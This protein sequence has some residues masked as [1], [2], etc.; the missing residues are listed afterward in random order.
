MVEQTGSPALNSQ[1]RL[2]DKNKQT[3]LLSSATTTKLY[4]CLES[5]F[6]LKSDFFGENPRACFSFNWE[7][8]VSKYD[9]VGLKRLQQ[10]C[11][12][13]VLDN[14]AMGGGGMNRNALWVDGERA[15]L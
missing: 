14:N 6:I 9:M 2:I 11:C 8:C 15:I 13:M 1:H 5:L 4:T 7:H 3:A 10:I 12:K